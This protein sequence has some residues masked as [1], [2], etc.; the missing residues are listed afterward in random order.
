VG[1]ERGRSPAR[2]R[3]R[4]GRSR[5]GS[6]GRPLPRPCQADL[7][8]VVRP[9][10]GDPDSD[11]AAL[12]TLVPL[13]HTFPWLDSRGARPPCLLDRLTATAEAEAEAEHAV[14]VALDA[15]QCRL[16][17]SLTG[18]GTG[19]SAAGGDC[20]LVLATSED[21]AVSWLRAGEALER[22]L[23]EECGTATG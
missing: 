11:L 5:P 9:A 14:L 1:H 21:E 12:A 8:A 22:V 20:A 7:A 18:T 16:L 2:R 13:P 4:H 15:A 10:N 17:A 23:L 6:H 3:Y 19:G